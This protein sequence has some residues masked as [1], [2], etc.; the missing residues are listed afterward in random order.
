MRDGQEDSSSSSR[1][2]LPLRRLGAWLFRQLGRGWRWGSR[3]PRRIHEYNKE[4][5]PVVGSYTNITLTF[6]NL[7]VL[8]ILLGQYWLQKESEDRVWSAQ[9]IS[10]IYDMEWAK[11]S[12]GKEVYQ[13]KA[14]LRSREDA[15]KAYI[16]LE[17]RK[18][19][20]RLTEKARLDRMTLAGTNLANVDFSTSKLIGT[21]L[22]NSNLI[23]STLVGTDLRGAIMPDADLSDADMTGA[24][25]Q[26]A[27]LSGAILRDTILE[28]ATLGICGARTETDAASGEQFVR[29]LPKAANCRGADFSG[30]VLRGTR[31]CG[32]DFSE[33]VGL[34]QEQIEAA[35]GDETT[36]LPP[37]LK[38]PR[39]WIFVGP[40]YKSL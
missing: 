27:K 35:R 17:G 14:S 21:N 15:V 36:K 7:V 30:A 11:D 12:S 34:T 8:A 5:S 4:Q 32:V 39:H 19:T 26:G 24:N 20:A 1:A 18:G 37:H 2:G 9:Q 28:R 13:P 16:A 23:G 29:A 40:P 25:A 31:V 33:A 22:T 38:M 3:I 10:T 6:I